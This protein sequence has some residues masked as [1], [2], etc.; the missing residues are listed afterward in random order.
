MKKILAL[1]LAL[2]L[3]VFA[4]AACGKKKA[5]EADEP[6][7]ATGEKGDKGDKGD[8]GIQ[9]EKGE[10]G[11]QGIQGEKGEQG[12]TG[13]AG[14][15]GED[16][17]GIL[18]VEIKDGC[19]WITYS[20]D[21]YNPVNV[22]AV[23]EEKPDPKG[24]AFKLLPDGTY[25]VS[26]DSAKYSEKI[27]IPASFDGKLVTKI[28]EGAF[29]DAPYLTE[30][31]I[32]ET[33]T[34]IGNNAF[35]GCM[36]LEIVSIPNSVTEIGNQAFDGC[37][38]LETIN[39]PKS[40]ASIGAGAF[41]GCVNLTYIVIPYKVNVIASDTFYKCT[42][43]NHVELHE[44]ITRISDKAFMDCSSLESIKI[45]QNVE[46]IGIGAFKGCAKLKSVEF[47]NIDGWAANDIDIEKTTLVDVAKAA[48]LLT[49]TYV[50]VSWKKTVELEEASA[51]VYA[52]YDANIRKEASLDHEVEILI[53]VSFMEEMKLLAKNDMWSYV[54][55]DDNGTKIEGYI[56]NDLIT[57]DK[58][59]I[60]FTEVSSTKATIKTD[61]GGANNANVRKSPLANGYPHE[62]TVLETEGFNNS[63]IIGQL[64][65]G[66]EVVILGVS[67]VDDN[68]Q[69]WAYVQGEGIALEN[70]AIASS[71]PVMIEG[72]I[73][74]DL[75][76]IA[77]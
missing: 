13:A 30:I 3:V 6:V 71:E 36:A 69:K 34:A 66:T 58:K 11:A 67:M 57:T 54:E 9:G 25:E 73:L 17:R 8:Q 74:Y 22:G 16:G 44:G 62:F 19:L 37:S 51:T 12:L 48:E 27:E 65:K 68:N 46:D 4:F 21:P 23:V 39:L 49:T 14:E 76:V 77:V 40:V 55:Y 60:T 5:P 29:A 45:F 42:R 53:T 20:D 33:V 26:A 47:V 75:L 15:A 1:I 59:A 35:K 31:V 28:S 38:A 61:L 43:L 24:L 2:L 50:D 41:Q 32:P 72:F 18:K 52:L 7:I 63:S 70:G 10:Q 56:A 64:A